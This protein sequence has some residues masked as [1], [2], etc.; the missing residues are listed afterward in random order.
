M[1][2]KKKLKDIREIPDL[3]FDPMQNSGLYQRSLSQN[4]ELQVLGTQ[5]TMNPWIC[6]EWRDMDYVQADESWA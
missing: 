1:D 2:F 3:A 5:N 4:M 6:R